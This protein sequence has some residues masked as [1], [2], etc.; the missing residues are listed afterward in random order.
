[1][2]YLRF[3][4]LGHQVSFCSKEYDKMTGATY[5]EAPKGF[6]PHLHIASL[7]EGKL[8]Y[9][10]LTPKALHSEDELA[11]RQIR[12]AYTKHETNGKDYF[13]EMRANLVLAYK[14]KQYTFDEII[15][16]DHKMKEVKALLRSGD[17]AS[18][19]SVTNT[20]VPSGALTSGY[21]DKVKTDINTYIQNNYS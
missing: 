20:I 21:I 3:N 11:K 10:L 8:T 16:I 9:E 17:W 12:S 4:E 15:E 1:M 5:Y 6:D 7:Q 19:L 2:I 13:D 14:Q 18:A